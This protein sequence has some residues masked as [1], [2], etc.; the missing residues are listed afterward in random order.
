MNE[1]NQDLTIPQGSA[2]NMEIVYFEGTADEY[3]AFIKFQG[4]K[5]V[6]KSLDTHFRWVVTR[7]DGTEY[8]LRPAE[9]KGQ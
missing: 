2:D 8:I 6:L 5:A 1:S 3:V 7:E 9:A 4:D